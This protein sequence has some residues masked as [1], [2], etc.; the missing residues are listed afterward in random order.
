MVFKF[1]LKYITGN[2]TENKVMKLYAFI[3]ACLVAFV[4]SYEN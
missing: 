1:Y 3:P 4:E 2:A